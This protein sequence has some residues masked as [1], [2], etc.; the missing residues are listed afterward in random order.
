[1]GLAAA[2]AGF[3]SKLN[4][5]Q[6]NLPLTFRGGIAYSPIKYLLLSTDLEQVIER[7]LA[8]KI[9]ME[10]QQL[11]YI[12]PR[13]GFLYSNERYDLFAG[14]GVDFQWGDFACRIDYSVNPLYTIE[15]SNTIS[16][17]L[18]WNPQE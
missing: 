11:K 18:K 12:I 3:Q 15:F 8:Y 10:I 2:N 16:G 17:T 7:D 4:Q 6:S 1:L 9:G 5:D 13:A 14:L